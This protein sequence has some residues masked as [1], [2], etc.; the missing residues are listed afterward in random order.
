MPL[1]WFLQMIQK[2]YKEYNLIHKQMTH[3]N[4]FFLV[5]QIHTAGL[6]QSKSLTNDSYELIFFCV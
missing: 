3:M 5:N 1:K 2:Q 6:A 4:R